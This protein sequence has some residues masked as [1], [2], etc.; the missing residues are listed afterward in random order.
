MDVDTRQ[1]QAAEAEA[2]VDADVDA[3]AQQSKQKSGRNAK[4]VT[5]YNVDDLP[6]INACRSFM[7]CVMDAARY[8]GDTQLLADAPTLWVGTCSPG[9]IHMT[10]KK[11]MKLRKK[12]AIG[13]DLWKQTA[14]MAFHSRK[15]RRKGAH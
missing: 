9:K 8:R 11:A 15:S 6:C 10:K 13:D 14:P 12:Q 3:G 5:R 7:T 2:D 1:P 4:M